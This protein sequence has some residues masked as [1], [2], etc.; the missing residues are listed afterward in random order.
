MVQ[1]LLLLVSTPCNH[2]D[3]PE[4][5]F[6]EREMSLIISIMRTFILG[7]VLAFAPAVHSE[8]LVLSKAD[9]LDR[10]QAV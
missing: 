1:L 8:T 10:V 2:R 9:Y 7:A 3:L 5:D 4:S 6:P